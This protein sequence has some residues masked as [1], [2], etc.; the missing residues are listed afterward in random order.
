MDLW[1]IF[2]D[3]SGLINYFQFYKRNKKFEI[4]YFVIYLQYKVSLTAK[5]FRIKNSFPKKY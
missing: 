5:N 1:P 4:K 3:P 2:S